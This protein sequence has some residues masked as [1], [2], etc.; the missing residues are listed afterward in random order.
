MQKEPIIAV[1][2]KSKS[3]WKVID[4]AFLILTITIII[5]VSYSVRLSRYNSELQ[6]KLHEDAGA[7]CG[8]QSSQEG[9]IV[10]SFSSIDLQGK[11]NHVSFNGSKK[12]LLFIFSP[13]CDVCAQEIALWNKLVTADVSNNIMV[14]GVS[15]DSF[16]ES[17]KSI[18]DKNISLD[19]LI[20]SDN[21]TLRAYRVVSIP[22]IMVVSKQGRVEW[23]HNGAMNQDKIV[24]LKSKLT[25]S[26][27]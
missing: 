18:T 21:P 14:Y 26:R 17:R 9:D 6:K 23:V 27:L 13:A 22:Q 19:I 8:P 11:Q 10:P 1:A 5:A 25:G 20:M 7:L 3:I 2:E 15:I 12:L 4:P 16:E 24:E